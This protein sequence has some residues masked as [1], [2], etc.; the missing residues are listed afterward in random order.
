MGIYG[1]GRTYGPQLIAE[2]G[3]VFWFTH[4][5]TLTAF[6]SVNPGANQ[7]GQ[8]NFKSNRAL[9]IG[10]TRLRKTLFQII[11]TLLQNS[12]EDNPVYLFLDKK[13][14]KGTS[15][16]VYM[17]AGA[18]KFLR[19]YYGKVNECLHNLEQSE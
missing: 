9:K 17:T 8:Q 11:T 16:Y 1:I 3:N 13:R 5:E 7:S 18:N 2:I 12:P 10:S 4:S 14:S 15:Y 6:A 19:I